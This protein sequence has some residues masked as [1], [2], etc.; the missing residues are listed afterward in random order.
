MMPQ[1]PAL[2]QG[3]GR[4]ELQIVIAGNGGIRYDIF[5]GEVTRDDTMIVSPF[6]DRFYIF[7]GLTSAEAT[8]VLDTM[9]AFLPGDARPLPFGSIV[10]TSAPDPEQPELSYAIICLDFDLVR[11]V[12]AF[13]AF[14]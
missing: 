5:Q 4:Q 14:V 9:H 13:C 10:A 6:R 8:D 3:L 2:H 7:S 12:A 11:V 1:G